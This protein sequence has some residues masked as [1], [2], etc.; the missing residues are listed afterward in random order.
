MGKRIIITDHLYPPSPNRNCDWCA[1]WDGYEP[2]DPIG[3][4]A[5]E[6]EAIIDLV[7]Y[8]ETLPWVER[9]ARSH[10]KLTRG[11]VACRTC[12]REQR[13]DSAECLHKGWP[14]CCTYTMTLDVEDVRAALAGGKGEG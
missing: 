4:G 12:G 8:A 13:V 11:L 3:S 14:K 7:N 10:P 1:T 2:G 6:A 9:V 5:T